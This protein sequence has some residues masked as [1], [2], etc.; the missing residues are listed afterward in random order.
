MSRSAP[1]LQD[2]AATHSGRPVSDLRADPVSWAHALCDVVALARPDVIVSHLDPHLETD[3]LALGDATDIV[4][5]L[6]DVEDLAML[7]PVPQGSTSSS[8]SPHPLRPHR[9]PR[10][11]ARHRR[12]RASPIR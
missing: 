10:L 1:I 7:R 3:A 2:V 5:A 6:Y 12:R 8:T 9:P 11:R 4:D